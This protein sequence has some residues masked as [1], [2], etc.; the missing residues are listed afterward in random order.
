MVMSR[1]QIVCEG[2]V[3]NCPTDDTHEQVSFTIPLG[4]VEIRATA[5]IPIDDE[6][7]SAVSYSSG[8][9]TVNVSGMVKPCKNVNGRDLLVSYLK[10]G[11]FDM[12]TL[13]NLPNEGESRVRVYVKPSDIKRDNSGRSASPRQSPADKRDARD[14]G[15]VGANVAFSD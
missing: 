9:K 8:G 12:V 4:F 3:E 14:D 13:V 2:T 15:G 1:D 11:V 7:T 6:K 10:L 5:I